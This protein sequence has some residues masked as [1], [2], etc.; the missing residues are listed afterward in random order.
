MEIDIKEKNDNELT[1]IVEDVDVS[2]INAIRR[3]CT[4]EVSTMAID[5]VSIF[6]NDSTLFDEVLAHR[7]GLVPL[8]TDLEAFVLPSEC[9][10]D[11]DCPSCSASLILKEKGPKVVYSGDLVSAH[12][13][14]RPVYD[15]IP[16]LKL[17]EGEEVELEA[18]AKLGIGLEHAK[19]QPT[20]TCAYKYY[21]LIT[22]DDSCEVCMKCVN[23]CPKNVLEYDESENKII[24]T[25]IENCSA[26][27][28]CMN[29]CEQG[30]IHVD[31]VDDKFIFKIETD[32]SLSPEEVL[33]NACD[34]LS[35]K[36]EKIVAFCK[37]GAKK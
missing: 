25:D 4:V 22:I 2:F 33:K 29:N 17:K 14:V 31:A 12:E 5:T 30:A 6:K 7:L 23:E 35:Q 34:I 19:W 36:S 13:A 18:I 27:K 9:D 37:G 21:P 26:C 24:I 16:L 1:F 15:S 20:T 3:I 28:T 32:G 8:E 11:D 10:C